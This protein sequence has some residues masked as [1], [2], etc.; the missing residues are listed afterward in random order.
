MPVHLNSIVKNK[1]K[2]NNI[3]LGIIKKDFNNSTNV[4]ISEDK[5][6]IIASKD[7]LDKNNMEIIGKEVIT[8]KLSKDGD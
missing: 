2:E 7:I 5:K 8:T 1:E 4:F 6:I 3:F